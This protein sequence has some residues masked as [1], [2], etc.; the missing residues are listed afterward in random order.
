MESIAKGLLIFPKQLRTYRQK[1]G[2]FQSECWKKSHRCRGQVLIALHNQ[3]TP[4][5][6][7][8][9]VMWCLRGFFRGSPPWCR[10]M[11]VS[12]TARSFVVAD[13]VWFSCSIQMGCHLETIKLDTLFPSS[14]E[15]LSRKLYWFHSGDIGL[16]LTL[17]S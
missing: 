3:G 14:M 16:I 13:P 2:N 6:L 8:T 1:A 12:R 11:L 10:R 15:N 4:N 9:I 7:G 17:K 5:R